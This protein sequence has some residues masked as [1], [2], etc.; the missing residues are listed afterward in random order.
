MQSIATLF[1]QW[2][3]TFFVAQPR[4]IIA[5]IVEHVTFYA[6]YKMCSLQRDLKSFLKLLNG[7]KTTNIFLAHFRSL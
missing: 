7:T 6:F 3:S 4:H 2:F 5:L 1:D